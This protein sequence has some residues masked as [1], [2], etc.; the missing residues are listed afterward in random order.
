[1]ISRGGLGLCGSERFL[2]RVVLAWSAEALLSN[3]IFR[4]V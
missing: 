3:E 4:R 2:K 1:V